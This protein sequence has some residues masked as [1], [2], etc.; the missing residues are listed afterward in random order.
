M[1]VLC[2]EGF[3]ATLFGTR[4]SFE[5]KTVNA[6]YF[7]KRRE[8]YSLNRK[9]LRIWF[10]RIFSIYVCIFVVR[11]LIIGFLTTPF[12]V[13]FLPE[14]FISILVSGERVLQISFLIL[15]I[16]Y[17]VTALVVAKSLR[18]NTIFLSAYFIG[19]PIA[20]FF[21]LAKRG[22]IVSSLLSNALIG[23]TLAVYWILSRELEEEGKEYS[24]FQNK[25]R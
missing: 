2:E 14:S 25:S 11:M 24:L 18:K 23:S 1:P 20:L 17:A 12:L 5:G 10:R 9:T 19:M 13:K 15:Y 3:R 16:L 7:G 6:V 8:S 21:L 22:G 4:S